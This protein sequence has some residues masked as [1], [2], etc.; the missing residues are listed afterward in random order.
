MSDHGKRIVVQDDVLESVLGAVSE[1]IEDARSLNGSGAYHSQLEM[2]G[3]IS[4]AFHDM[5]S[6]TRVA[7]RKE[8]EMALYDVATAAIWGLAS[9]EQHVGWEKGEL[10]AEESERTPW[11]MK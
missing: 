2:L 11:Y 7:S 3:A 5:A 10:E 4:S 6:V 9:L 8:L 1:S